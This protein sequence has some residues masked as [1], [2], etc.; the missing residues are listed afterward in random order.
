M[1]RIA[2]LILVLVI[3]LVGVF[4][5]ADA[6]SRV[7][8]YTRRDGTYVQPYTR[9]SPD[10]Y[11]SNNKGSQSYGGSQRDEYSSGMGATNKKNSS[12]GYRDNDNDGLSNSYDPKPESGENW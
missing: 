3:G 7:R 1:K 6:G 5:D 2:G 8:G 11:R 12:Y 9:S 4:S 10:S